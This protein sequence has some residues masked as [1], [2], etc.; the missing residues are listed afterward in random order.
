MLQ[1]TLGLLRNIDLAVFQAV[2]QVVRREIDQLDGVRLVENGIWN[3]LA[4]THVGDLRDHVIQAFDVLDIDR[5][6][7][8]DAVA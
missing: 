7:D 4:N 3:R 5:A 1:G 2:N 6:V 8:V